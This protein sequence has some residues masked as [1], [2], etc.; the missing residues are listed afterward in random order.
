M[1]IGGLF[2]GGLIHGG[3]LIYGTLRYIACNNIFHV[4]KLSVLMEECETDSVTSQLYV[5]G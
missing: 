2:S 3:G 1:K 5:D 4:S